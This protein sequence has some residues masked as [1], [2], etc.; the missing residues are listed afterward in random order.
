MM[1]TGPR[2]ALVVSSVPF[3]FVGEVPRGPERHCSLCV[4]C[5]CCLSPLCAGQWSGWDMPTSSH[6]SGEGSGLEEFPVEL[7][8][9]LFLTYPGYWLAWCWLAVRGH[10][11]LLAE[12]KSPVS[13]L[14]F[15]ERGGKDGESSVEI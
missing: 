11:S 1:L 3:L 8:E 12:R 6:D 7:P 13:R 14:P 4:F 15:C 9:S 10:E 5:N 2:V